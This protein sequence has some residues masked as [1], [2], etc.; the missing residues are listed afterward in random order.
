MSDFKELTVWQ[1]AH[2][3]ALAAYRGTARFPLGER[4]GLTAQIRRAAVSVSA[5]IAESCG[6]WHAEDQIRFLRTAQGSARELEA[7]LLLARDLELMTPE[8][9][10][11]LM[12]SVREVQRMRVGLI[13]SKRRPV[14]AHSA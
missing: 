13:R 4:F 3:L 12:N 11:E 2:A 9:A 5:N 14:R 6:R 8:R 7:E 1:R 10:E